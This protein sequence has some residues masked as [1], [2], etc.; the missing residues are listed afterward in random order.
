MSAHARVAMS[1]L[2]LAAASTV[3]ASPQV[4]PPPGPPVP[5]VRVVVPVYTAEPIP[6][7]NGSSWTTDLWLSNRGT[8][9]A[10]AFGVLWDCM[11]PECG[12]VPATVDPGRSLQPQLIDAE[13]ALHGQILWL[14]GAADHD[15]RLSLRFRDLSRQGS[16]WG[17]ELPVPREGDFARSVSLID[18]PVEDGF[19]QTLRIYSLEQSESVDEVTVAVY[20]LDPSRTEPSG[21][22]DELLGAST[23]TFAYAP[24][25]SP[26]SFP[27]HPGYAE[28]TDLSTLAPL[29]DATRLR[30]QI[31]S[32]SAA[33][34]V[35]AFAT[36]IHNETQ[37]ATV[38]TP[39]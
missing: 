23:L 18:V 33:V 17:T 26:G 39:Q 19:R 38:I 32:P 27:L 16:T 3:R 7:V 29:G 15:L 5:N 1:L 37:H 12:F 6:G 31:E 4:Q 30:L 34:R 14:D 8:E 10:T 25:P 13:A 20:R 28:V 21:D 36:V 11:I 22:A 35:W 9:P 2:V 24:P